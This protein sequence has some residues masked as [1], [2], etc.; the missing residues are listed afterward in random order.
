MP[1]NINFLQTDLRN[2]PFMIMNIR[3]LVLALLCFTILSSCAKPPASSMQDNTGASLSEASYAVSRSIVSLSETAQAAH[4]ISSL[5]PPPNPASYGMAG[6]TSI[7][8]SGPIEPLV[9]QIA[10]AA[11]YQMR[12]LGVPPAIPVLVTVYDKN[13]MLA[14]VLRDVAYQCGRR[15]TVVVYPESRVIELRYAKN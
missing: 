13:R 14:D 4:P 9:R 3:P 2:A 7:D 1:D 11:S 15:A 8:W 5:E 10:K 6:L 12:V